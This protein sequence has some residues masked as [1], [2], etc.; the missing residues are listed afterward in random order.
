MCTI[1]KLSWLMFPVYAVAQYL[2]AIVGSAVVYGVYLGKAL[3]IH[4]GRMVPK[5]REQKTDIYSVDILTFAIGK[6]E[7]R[8]NI[9]LR[10]QILK[11]KQTRIS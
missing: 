9:L 10:I 6:R 7:I 8:K 1:G 4:P 2:G 3:Q 5:Q 11:T